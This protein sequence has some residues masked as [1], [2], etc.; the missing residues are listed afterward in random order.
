MDPLT[1][2]ELTVALA[3][4]AGILAQSVSRLLRLP[5]IVLLLA[6]GALLGP[7]GAGWIQP[8][9]LGEG[10]FAIVDFGVAVILFEGGLNLQ[11]SRLKRQEAPIRRLI[12]V[13]ALVTFV[14]AAVLAGLVLDWGL[15]LAIQFGALVVVTGP[16]VI[17]PLLRDMRLRPRIKTVLE[18]EGVLIDPIGALLAGFILSI[19][20]VP[21]VVTLASQTAV[22][23]ASIG[24]GLLA[25]LATGFLLAW[26]LRYRL[27]VARGHENIFTLAGIVLLFEACNAVMEP[28]GLVA[29]TVAGVVMGNL[30][31]RVGHD[32][33]EFKD[34][35]TVLLVGMLFIL[36]SADVALDDVRALGLGGLV[37][38]AG[39]ILVVRPLSVWVATRGSQLTT[40]E[41]VFIGAIAPRGIVAAAIAT[42]T[43]AALDSQGVAGGA[44]LRALVFSTIAG[45][46]V[47]S[48][49]IAHPLAWALG[50]QLPRRDRVVIF[51]ARGLALPLADA[52]RAGGLRV[53]FIES[54]PKRSHVAE[55]AGHTVI[56]GNAL[57]DRTLQRARLELV[58]TVI[59][60]TFNEHAN[61]LFVKEAREQHGV[62]LGYIAMESFDDELSP[63]LVRRSGIDILFN[64]SHDHARWD[65]RWRHGDVDV[66]RVE[67]SPVL[68]SPDA[69]DETAG[70]AP[71]G[72]S[73]ME[74]GPRERYV[75]LTVRR[76]KTVTPYHADH[77]PRPGDISTVALYRPE[78][79]DALALLALDGW[80]LA[81]DVD[82][83]AD[84]PA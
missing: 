48:G 84:P 24:F 27:L 34:Q 68:E 22:V 18:A 13:G 74:T 73:E 61:S 77:Q 64:G 12:T 47:L 10:L 9:A 54:D 30:E 7:E 53:S 11:W 75:L 5:G 65:V 82:K 26:A 28:S 50:L 39:L 40:A 71:N 29:V 57:D 25:G 72:A 21:Q 32:L 14:S 3:L 63:G 60:S 33:R 62:P 46:V 59:G 76:G 58:G 36:L 56:F 69:Q 55:Q 38:V 79:A 1:H 66:A 44:A 80:R 23:I 42:I 43:A 41:R 6:C 17:Q 35:L 45:T 78:R 19:V 8:R 15:A 52:L 70:A 4:A 49:V 51:G 31:T 37:V 20:I 83:V 81:T 16:T 2:P 67:W